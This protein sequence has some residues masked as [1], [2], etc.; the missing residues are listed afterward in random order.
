[1]KAS[2]MKKLLKW[3]VV[4]GVPVLMKGMPG[5]GKSDLT[6]WVKKKTKYDQLILHPVVDEPTDYKGLGFMVKGKAEFV[7]YGNLL[8]L[9]EA[10]K[11]LIVVFEDLGQAT[12]AV[13]KAIMQLLLAREINGKPLSKH[14]RFIACTNRK[15]DRA[16]V[17]GILET[18]KSRFLTIV[19][20]EPDVDEWC[21]WATKKKL[22]SVLVSYAQFRKNH[23][24]GLFQ[25]KPTRDLTNSCIPRTFAGVGFMLKKKLPK[26]LWR[27]SF[28][29]AIGH[30]RATD[31][32]AYIN[33]YAKLPKLEDIQK[34]PSRVPVPNDFSAKYAL[35]GLLV[36]SMTATHM[37]A[38]IT[39]LERMGSEL[40]TAAM[41]MTQ[42]RNKEATKNAAYIQWSVKH[43]ATF[44]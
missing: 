6:K 43:Q 2:E 35:M 32:I 22:P 19:E 1:M 18:V 17:S 28:T 39:F 10:K 7:P 40:T 3:S 41:K 24:G 33:I 15:Q 44:N 21:K 31:L 8:K 34:N 5:V 37:K 14:V 29:G 16:G 11:P 9:M 23:E 25:F 13:Q 4:N 36:D 38:Y 42:Y 20:L 27:E 30:F 12:D 26:T